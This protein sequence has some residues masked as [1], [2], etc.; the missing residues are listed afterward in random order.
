MKYI[1]STLL[2]FFS[3]LATAQ[4]E[5][6]GKV[7]DKRGNPI[8]ASNV[9]LEEEPEIGG[10]TD[11]DGMFRFTTNNAY[12]SLIVSFIGY[13]T[14]KIKLSKSLIEKE[15]VIKLE[16]DKQTLSE[17]IITAQDPISK[18]NSVTKIKKLDIYFNPVAQGDPL[19]AITL[20]PASTT[21]DE[22]AKPSLR[23]SSPDRS[24]ITLN[25][26]PVYTPVRSS[27]L[28]NQ[29]FFS[30]FNPQI[31]DNQYVYASNP[32][33]TYGNT[34][35][36]LVEIQ[37]LRRLSKNQKQ[38]TLSIG[39]IGFFLSQKI[40]KK[41]QTFVQLYGNYQS[42]K[43]FVGMQKKHFVGLKGYHTKDVGLNT[44]YQLSKNVEFNSFNYAID[45]DFEA[46]THTL[47]YYGQANADKKR[48]FTINNLNYYTTKGTFSL[49]TGFSTSSQYFYLGNLQ[50]NQKISQFYS[51]LNFKHQ[52]SS[53][54]KLQT[55]MS[56]DYHRNNFND[57][58]P[59]YYFAMQPSA[60]SL[61]SKV[62]IENHIVEAYAFSDWELSDK[63]S[64]SAGI[65][66][67]IPVQEQSQYFNFQA[68]AKYYLNDKNSILLS[69]GNYHSYATPNYYNKSFTLLSSQQYACD[70]T[71]KTK[72]FG[73][74]MA[75]YYKTEKGNQSLNS[76]TKIDN[77]KTFGV[78]AF[79]EYIF[80][81]HF[82]IIASNLFIDQKLHQGEKKFHGRYDFN[83][84]TKI[85]L[86]FSKANWFSASVSF[87]NRPGHY[88]TSVDK[89]VQK[90]N[91]EYPIP[92]FNE[93]W[94]NSQYKS[95]NRVDFS[96]N[97]YT[98][99][100][101]GR[102]IIPYLSISNILNI[103]NE[104]S[105]YYSEDFNQQYFANYTKRI[106]YF[107]VIWKL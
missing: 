80:T 17:V 100:K 42:S 96:M 86:Q 31:I 66:T 1:I 21:T 64:F 43:A 15:L 24:R 72:N 49:N 81:K 62:N 30:L 40:K 3:I 54:L 35:A 36:G 88:Y 65:R 95:Y 92:I 89:V 6:R 38:F 37:T 85:A 7:V 105:I 58:V 71:Y 41:E 18:K 61:S 102:A 27:Q 32:P 78:E 104:S 98:P 83:H 74:K 23:G 12:G 8:F 5:I 103:K 4:V 79:A 29:G 33:L 73:A 52:L 10:S 67:N 101:N 60:P 14:K 106:F 22:T 91:F 47:N 19:K 70:Y 50:S 99:L 44:H 93:E 28:N 56:Y 46:N 25:G 13:K 97:R 77:I 107:G 57:S 90:P 76:Y 63:L 9:Y 45:E 84:L 82:K 16:E 68:S 20:L 87:T 75:V 34:S 59:K 39:S 11:F 94:N 2:C 48:F 53:K 26:I 51:S 69:G 55:G